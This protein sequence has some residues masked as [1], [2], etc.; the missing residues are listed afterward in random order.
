MMA[1]VYVQLTAE[2]YAMRGE[3]D[4]AMH[5]DMIVLFMTMITKGADNSRAMYGKSGKRGIELQVTYRLELAV[6]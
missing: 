2:R 4:D 5:G 3:D 6:W 1:E